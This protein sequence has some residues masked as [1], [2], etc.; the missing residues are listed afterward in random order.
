MWKHCQTLP[1]P[2]FHGINPFDLWCH[3][4]NSLNLF[5]NHKTLYSML[6]TSLTRSL[7]RSLAVHQRP[8]YWLCAIGML[9]SS[10]TRSFSG[11]LGQWHS[12]WYLG[13]LRRQGISSYKIDILTWEDSCLPWEWIPMT[14]DVSLSMNYTKCKYLFRLLQHVAGWY[15]TISKSI[16]SHQCT[17]MCFHVSSIQNDIYGPIIADLC[18]CQ[19]LQRVDLG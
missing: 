3:L 2:P 9:L 16:L 8:R 7:A 14:S 1:N 17:A 11:E 19:F 4:Y 18:V 15:W 12:C 10:L 13:S 6:L 5:I